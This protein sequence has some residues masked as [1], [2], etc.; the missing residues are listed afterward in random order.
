MK[1]AWQML[2]ETDSPST[3][4]SIHHD[5]DRDGDDDDEEDDNTHTFHHH[6]F[7]GL[8]SFSITFLQVAICYLA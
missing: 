7:N 4:Q 2:W 6:A 5:E 3:N 8:N 1:P